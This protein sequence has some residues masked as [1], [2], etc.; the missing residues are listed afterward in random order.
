M[1]PR[2][3]TDQTASSAKSPRRARPSLRANASKIR[4]TIAAFSAAGTAGL[5]P[6][7]QALAVPTLSLGERSEP[8]EPPHLGR[9]V[10]L[11]RGLEVLALRSG[12]A[13]LWAEPAKEAEG[14]A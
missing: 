4:R 8:H 1:A 10:V 9:V 6:R 13:Q 11:D 3:G 14:R 7:D 2:P 5:P 12:L